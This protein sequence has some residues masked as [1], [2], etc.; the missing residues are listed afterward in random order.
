[1][2]ERFLEFFVNFLQKFFNFFLERVSI[3]FF[4]IIS[5]SQNIL[6]LDART[7]GCLHGVTFWKKSFADAKIEICN[8]TVFQGFPKCLF[9]PTFSGFQ[10]Q[11]SE[12]LANSPDRF[13]WLDPSEK[14]MWWERKINFLG[15]KK[16]LIDEICDAKP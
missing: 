11:L 12:F 15:K 1:M 8:N 10:T 6:R 2:K 16:L 13:V 3:I 7:L 9:C 4:H 14:I 5:I